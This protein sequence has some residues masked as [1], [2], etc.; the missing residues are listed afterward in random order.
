[1]AIRKAIQYRKELDASDAYKIKGFYFSQIHQSKITKIILILCFRT[2]KG[3]FKQ[4]LSYF[5]PA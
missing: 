5:R 4:S 2:T 3:H 1:M